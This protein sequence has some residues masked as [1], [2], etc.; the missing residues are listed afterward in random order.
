MI[1]AGDV[2][3]TKTIL[4]LFARGA[5]GLKPVAV[6]RFATPDFQSL[7]AMV[8]AFVPAGTRLE[9]ACLGL[10]GAIVDG[11]AE[12]VNVGWVVE[13]ERFAQNL[14]LERAVL[15]ND[16]EAMAHGIAALSPHQVI[17][18]NEGR[19]VAAR[20]AALIAA[21]T[22]LGEA[23]LY[24]NGRERV[25]TACEAGHADFAPRNALEMGFLAWMIDAH[26][27][28]VSWDSVLSGRGLADAYRYLRD[29]GAAAE[30]PEDA[31][32]ME[33][34]DPAAVVAREGLSAASP[35]CAAA[36]DLFANMYG[37][38]AGNL[39]LRSL[40]L[41]GVYV[42]GGVAAKLAPKLSDGTFL[43]AFVTKDRMHAMLRDVPVKLILEET[44]ALLGAARVA[45]AG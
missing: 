3:G 19:P 25:P 6:S 10:P 28:P 4:G 32:R 44:T 1:L 11:A 34:E 21:G 8:E 14:G 43:K 2:G 30:R 16:L 26:K 29:A 7:E 33:Q 38:E 22:G 15:L 13:R 41:G 24:W 18:L 31:R 17:V 20:N 5:D 39:A 27:G 35:L 12:L 23:V 42:G 36:L 45:A 40:A 37:A 9:G